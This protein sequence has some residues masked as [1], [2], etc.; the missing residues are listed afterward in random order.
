MTARRT[1]LVLL[2]AALAGI[3]WYL[4]G[5]GQ[6]PAGQPPLVRLTAANFHELRLAFDAASGAPRVIVML[7]PT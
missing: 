3:A 4:Y 1:V 6:T 5:G 2:A 7:S